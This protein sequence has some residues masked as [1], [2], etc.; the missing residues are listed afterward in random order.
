VAT[1]IVLAPA[2]PA[3]PR[4]QP[5]VSEIH[6]RQAVERT[7]FTDA[8]LV[9]GFLKIAFGAELSL[10]GRADRIRKYDG[11]VRIYIDSRAK[12]DRRTEVAAVVSDIRARVQH[13][14]IA[15]TGERS[16]AN[17][18]AILVRDR[19]LMRTIAA[20][21]GPKRAR[22]IRRFLRPQCLSSLAKDETFRIVNSRVILAVDVDPFDF[23][24]CAYEELLQSLGPNNDTD[25]PWTMF[26]DD[27]RMGYFDIYDQHILNILYHPRLK[28][29]MTVD[30][31]IGQLPLVLPAVRAWVANVNGL[32][33]DPEANDAR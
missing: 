22:Q 32:G 12:P 6:A 25:L 1:L 16:K 30:E 24:D 5:G 10:G 18:E 33:T 29:G 27:V 4:A 19:D 28:P 31:V 7:A 21:Y 15:V 20:V 23:Y 3:A 2:L 26:N 14:D 13:L 17:M 11:P 8:E 9:D